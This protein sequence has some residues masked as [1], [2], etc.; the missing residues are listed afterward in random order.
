M[1]PK[2]TRKRSRKA[3][4][5]AGVSGAGDASVP[6]PNVE[7]TVPPMGRT[8]DTVL[9]EIQVNQTEVQLDGADG[10]L[11][12]TVRQLEGA[13]SQLGA[14]AGQH[15]DD[16]DGE[17]EGACTRCGKMGHFARECPNVGGDR[18]CHTCGL[19]GHLKKDC[20]KQADGQNKNRSG[21][22]RPD[23]NRGQTSTPRVY[24]LSKDVEETGP[25]KAITGNF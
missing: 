23:Q 9:T 16:P 19:K 20:P 2:G 17:A 8:G 7:L 1:C 14:A 18:T 21:G 15:Q 3:K 5:G 12:E 6:N 13:G 24:E 10:Q 11:N 4:D 22:S 25:F